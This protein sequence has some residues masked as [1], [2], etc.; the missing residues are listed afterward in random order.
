MDAA[1]ENPALLDPAAS[2]AE[3]VAVNPGASVSAGSD[4]ATGG[5]ADGTNAV[6]G[7]ASVGTVLMAKLTGE[8]LRRAPRV[9]R[10]GGS[11]LVRQA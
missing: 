10:I 1:E 2:Q 6:P 8:V 9:D 11:W 3:G 5:V 7:L 4:L